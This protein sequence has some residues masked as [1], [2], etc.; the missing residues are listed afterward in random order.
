[1][2]GIIYYTDNRIS[3]PI[4]DNARR[5][6][7]ESGL[8]ITSTSLKPI[9]FGENTVVE[10]K[11]SY[12]TMVKQILTCL[13]N[14]TVD[15]VFFCENDVLYPKSHFDFTPPRDDIFYYNENVWR[16]YIGHDTAITYNRMLPLSV[17]CCNR[18]LGLRHYQLR[19]KLIEE[20]GL[21][22]IR[23]R[24]PRWARLW[25]YEPGT[26]KKKRGGLTDDDF[27]TWRSE[28]P[29]IDI[30]HPKT[31]SKPKIT[32]DS[33]KH[34][35]ENWQEINIKDIKEWNLASLFQLEMKSS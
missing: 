34:K 33:F 23:S 15:Y 22:A 5:F 14:S 13:E 26:K 28:E 6:I 25:G 19:Q 18:K 11:R 9:D 3:G 20:Q 21:S 2:K 16:W 12:P 1:M 30:R 31:F 17:M 27:G 35:P 10:G 4:I 7:K 32:L 8:P 29:V 24:E